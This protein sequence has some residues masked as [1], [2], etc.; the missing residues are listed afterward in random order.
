MLKNLNIKTKIT[1]G[2][3]AVAVFS[4]GI[5]SYL[6]YGTAKKN[7]R[8]QIF[9]DLVLTANTMEGSLL[10]FLERSKGRAIDF[11]SDGYI[12][13]GSQDVISK[14]TTALSSGLNEHLRQNKM[15]LDKTIYGIIIM[16]LGG[17]IVASTL[18]SEVGGTGLASDANFLTAKKLEKGEA[19][20]S[21]IF[22]SN[23]FRENKTPSFTAASP[24]MDKITQERIGVIM[25]FIKTDELND[26]LSGRQQIKLGARTSPIQ[27]RKTIETYLVNGEKTMI[28]E[29]RFLEDVILKKAVD[30]EPVKKCV[31]KKEEFVG[32][33]PDYRDVSVVGA[34]M[35]LPNGWTLLTEIDEN[36]VFE[37]LE[38]LKL[39]ILLLAFGV[40]FGV[41][42]LGYF[43]AIGISNPIKELANV[44]KKIG[45]GDLSQ[46][47]NIKSKDEI[48]RLAS[49]FNEM[50]EKLKEVDRAKSEFV[51]LAS[52]QL[53]TPPSAIKWFAE[54]LLN[55]KAGKII[56]ERQKKYL[57]EIA[58]N[59]K[60]MIDLVNQLLNVSRVELGTFAIEPRPTDI[61]NVAEEALE[62]LAPQIVK[63]ELNAIKDFDENMPLINTDPALLR[64][65]FQN[66]ISNA[67][68][69]TPEK[70]TIQLTIKKE[71]ENF[72]IKVADNGCGIP[73]NQQPK[74]FTKLFRADN[75]REIDPD[76]TGLGLYIVQSIVKE[77]GG[78]I[79]FESEENKGSAFYV[80]LPLKGLKKREGTK[81][82]H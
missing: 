70:G 82:L 80:V 77:M 61:S 26:I 19:S 16:D 38:K 41:S 27:K 32:I 60:R 72:F 48:G 20:V 63:K 22:F 9:D 17:R 69:Y 55:E 36:E 15:S 12:R 52:H 10:N 31:E 62:E 58:Y 44:A 78:A 74:I 18:D 25:N 1:L 73:K 71:T 47:A 43:L 66:L 57:Q 67:A 53:R 64:I 35:C 40:S 34:S 65:I 56:D 5:I 29:S 46:R 4:I 49:A 45:E 76:G 68:K 8:A 14:K 3:L 59:N 2:F 24:L 50:A 28:T 79:R 7:L 23:Y 11:S 81:G 39:N 13:D 54:M 33:Y 75:A 51:S 6:S 30:T 42:G 37:G 21:D